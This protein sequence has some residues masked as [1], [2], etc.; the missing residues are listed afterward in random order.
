MHGIAVALLPTVLAGGQVHM[1]PRF[2]AHSVW[3]QLATSNT[4]MAVPTMYHR[5]LAAYDDAN[6]TQRECWRRSA[7]ALTLSTSGSACLPVSLAERWRK[8]HG[9]IP[10]ERYGMTEIGVGLSSPLDPSQRRRGQV[11]KPLDTVELQLADESGRDAGDGPGE[12]WVRGPSV[13]SHYWRRL[14]ESEQ[15][16]QRGWFKTGDRAERDAHGAYR[17]LGRES[18]DILKSGGYKLS[19]LEIEEVL[20]EHPDIDEVAV[21]GIDDPEWGQRVVAS[22]VPRPGAATSSLSTANLRQWAK[23]QLAA[24]KVPREFV[25]FDALPTNAVGKVLKAQLASQ[26]AARVP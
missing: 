20:R 1:L 12:I 9:A 8:L 14:T 26:L 4:L 6:D 18:V 11:G 10:L 15:S 23:Q 5:L 24:Y 13:F 21:V 7:R 2:D 25:L 3:Q 19:A 17:I 22:V 16:F